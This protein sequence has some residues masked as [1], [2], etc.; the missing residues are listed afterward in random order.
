MINVS[1]KFLSSNVTLTAGQT[2]YDGTDFTSA[3]M[4]LTYCRY[5]SITLYVKGA[6]ASSSGTVSFA[7]RS[8]NDALGAWDTT[9]YL[10]LTATLSGTADVYV[11]Y[12]IT[13]DV[14]KLKLYSIANGD[15]SYNITANAALFMKDDTE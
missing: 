14:S 7:F 9:A 12:P 6:N 13:P 1:N 8:Y 15:T 2:Q 4:N 10:T 11:T 5:A 3:E